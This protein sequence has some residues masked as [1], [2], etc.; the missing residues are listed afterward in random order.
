MYVPGQYPYENAWSFAG[1]SGSGLLGNATVYM[2][3]TV[4]F[5]ISPGAVI[6]GDVYLVPGDLSAA[7]AAIYGLHQGLVAADISAP[8]INIERPAASATI[9]GMW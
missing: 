4:V 8:M 2:L 7:R 5:T 1:Q 9:S 6:E 3:P